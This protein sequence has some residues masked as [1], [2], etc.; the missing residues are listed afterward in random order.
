MTVSHDSLAALALTAPKDPDADTVNEWRE[1]FKKDYPRP[2]SELTLS[3]GELLNHLRVKASK[4]CDAARMKSGRSTTRPLNPPAWK[5]WSDFFEKSF[6]EF[7]A[8]EW[9]AIWAKRAAAEIE[10]QDGECDHDWLPL[11]LSGY[12]KPR[13][14]LCA[15]CD[16]TRD[17]LPTNQENPE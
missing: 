12:N 7:K 11:Y 9:P 8:L 4:A 15:H 17:P 10:R 14:Y 3:Q 1:Q 5:A 6:S 2:G 16:A 13:K